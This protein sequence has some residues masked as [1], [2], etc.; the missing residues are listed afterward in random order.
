MSLIS[1]WNMNDT[2]SPL[3]DSVNANNL[4]KIAGT[5]SSK[6]GKKNNAIYCDASTGYLN[7]T[8][9]NLPTGNAN[10]SH[11]FW[12]KPTQ[13][14]SDYVLMSSG[15]SVWS[16]QGTQYDIAFTSSHWFYLG[17]N[18]TGAWINDSN[19]PLNVWTHVVITKGAGTTI[20]NI[21]FYANTK[22]ITPTTYGNS[23]TVNLSANYINLNGLALNATT[24]TIGYRTI[25]TIDEWRFYNHVL[26]QQEINALYNIK[27]QIL[28]F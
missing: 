10:F 1:Y 27:P 21:L 19:I 8:P 17:F 26:S 3:V 5:F 28:I 7:T 16:V 25:F 14:N 24:P 18:S 23:A 15:A 20:Q 11:S 12:L 22:K 6:A 9:S 2:A 13:N 4:P